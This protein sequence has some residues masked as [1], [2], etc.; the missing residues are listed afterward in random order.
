[1]T[2]YT[3]LRDMPSSDSFRCAVATIIGDIE[4]ATGEP[5]CMIADRID[6]SLGTISN[7]KN[8]KADLNATYLARLGAVYGG[9]FLNPYLALFDAQAAPIEK[10]AKR[11]ILPIVT[12]VAHKIALARDPSGPGGATEVPQEKRGYLHD[13]KELQH[14]AGC[15]ISEVEAA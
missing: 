11:D 15:L 7:A 2:A 6:A 1:M 3:V 5:L 13:L 9:A 14:E 12:K 4:R 8:R 10:K